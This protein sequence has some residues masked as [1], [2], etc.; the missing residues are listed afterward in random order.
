MEHKEYENNFVFLK[1]N[2]FYRIKS[3]YA[4]N[5]FGQIY[6]RISREI[7]STQLFNGSQ[8]ISPKMYQNLFMC[9]SGPS[10]HKRKV[11][12]CLNFEHAVKLGYNELG[13]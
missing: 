7:L 11:F 6:L 4:K 10:I 2:L 8:K 12:E 13:C 3:N 1:L 5:Q 9:V